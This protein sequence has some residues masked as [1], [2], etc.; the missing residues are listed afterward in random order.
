MAA[1]AQGGNVSEQVRELPAGGNPIARIVGVI[2]SP[3]KTYQE[4]AAAPAW[5]PPL[6]VYIAVFLIAFTVYGAKADWLGNMEDAIRDFPTSRL[7]PDEVM[8]KVV[9]DQLAALK[10][11][12]W[13]QITLLNALNIVWG[14]VA[15]YHVMTLLYLTMFY[16][17]GSAA[18]VRVG[19]AWLTFLLCLAVLIG[20]SVINGVGQFV[21]QKDSP[22]TFLA[23]ATACVIVMVGVYIFLVNRNA[24]RDPGF[25]RFLSASTYASA[26]GI[27][28]AIAIAAISAATPAP[29]QAQVQYLVKSNLGAIMPSD[30]A[31]LQSLFSSLDIFSI[32]FLI[33][34][35]IGY[36]TMTKTSTGIAASITFLPWVVWVLIK[37]AWNAAVPS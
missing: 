19:K 14:S 35:T 21:L 15:F 28:G 20:G 4:I 29:I 12:N 34:L 3:A 37:L 11:Y 22:M 8:D 25:H 13:W 7:A 33:V 10:D 2:F 23:L 27:V 26:V 16:I 24:Q 30:N 1:I 32:W 5:L 18:D 17:M 36:K 9:A 31:A 6:L